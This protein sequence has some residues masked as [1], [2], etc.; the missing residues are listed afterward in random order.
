MP[1]QGMTERAGLHAGTAFQDGRTVWPL[2]AAELLV[3]D[4]SDGGIPE[5]EIDPRAIREALIAKLGS[6]SFR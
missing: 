3:V 2:S 5:L 4:D 6:D 1:R